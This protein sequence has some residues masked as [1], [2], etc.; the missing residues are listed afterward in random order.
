MTDDYVDASALAKRSTREP[1]STWVLQ[2]TEPSAPHTMLLAEITIVEVAAA[3][4][5]KQ[6]VPGGPTAEHGERMLSRSCQ[7]V[8]TPA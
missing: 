7:T 3:L 8:Q 4:A 5:A 6:R 1:G 2:M